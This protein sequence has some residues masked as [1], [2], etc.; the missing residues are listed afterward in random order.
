MM[1]WRYSIIPYLSSNIIGDVY[2]FGV[3]TGKSMVA[4]DNAFKIAGAEYRN[5]F[6]LDSFEGLPGDDSEV[7]HQA[8]WAKGGHNAME[9]F[10][11]QNVE[12][13]VAK[14]YNTLKKRLDISKIKLVPGFYNKTLNKENISKYNFGTAV[15]IDMDADHYTSTYEVLDFMFS[16]KLILGGVTIIGYDDWGGSIGWENNQSGE[17]KAHADICK[18]Y[19]VEAELLNQ[20]GIA[21]P[22]VHRIYKIHD[23]SGNI[24]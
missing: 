6:G 9:L 16:N 22:H 2:E 13:C 1:S 5:F 19:K 12:D 4:I 20:I 7:L 23:Y 3:Y 17:S 8:H 24:L 11:A 10:K 14:T 21:F 18:K 15:Y